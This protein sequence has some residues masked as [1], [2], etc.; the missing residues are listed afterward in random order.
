MATSVYFESAEQA[1]TAI[2][3]GLQTGH[4]AEDFCRDLHGT[5]T[6][7]YY[8][9]ESI[10][11]MSFMLPMGYFPSE[12]EQLRLVHDTLEKNMTV[13]AEWLVH[14]GKVGNFILTATSPI[15]IPLYSDGKHVKDT[16]TVHISLRKDHANLRRDQDH[17]P[18]YGFF[19]SSVQ[20]KQDP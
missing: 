8:D 2:R 3:A 14:G 10:R 6:V 5:C 1:I 4:W 19:V 17:K 12:S 15:P 11:K 9:E 20:V 13:I 7:S 16:H 18:K